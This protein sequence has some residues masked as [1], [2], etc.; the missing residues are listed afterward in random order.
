[1][2]HIYNEH[3]PVNQFLNTYKRK[4]H[5]YYNKSNEHNKYKN[6]AQ[7]NRGKFT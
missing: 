4:L 7:Y 5:K 2:I 6:I 3:L 1:M